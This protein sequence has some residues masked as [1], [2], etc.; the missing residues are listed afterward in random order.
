MEKINLSR[1]FDDLFEAL[2]LAFYWFHKIRVISISH[3]AGV[4]AM[5]LPPKRN[6]TSYIR[7][8]QMGYLK[9]KM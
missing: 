9:E 2:L 8:Q 7:R 6:H 1:I 5:L 4:T 3:S